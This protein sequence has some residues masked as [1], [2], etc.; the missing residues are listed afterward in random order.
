[1][2]APAELLI[3]VSALGQA[4]TSYLPPLNDNP[5][6]FHILPAAQHCRRTKNGQEGKIFGSA[7]PN[8]APCQGWAGEGGGVQ[9]SR[10]P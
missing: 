2:S 6:N 9:Q 7:Q 4:D 5:P 3:L 1:M 10:K 8:N